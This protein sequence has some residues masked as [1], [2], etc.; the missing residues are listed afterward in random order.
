VIIKNFTQLAKTEE[1]KLALE[2]IDAGLAAIDT[3]KIIKETISLGKNELRVGNESFS[4]NEIARIFVVG[5][6][7]CALSAAGALEEI[8]GRKLS[9]GIVIDVRSGKLNKIKTISGD[10]PMPSEKNVFATDEIIELLKNTS[11]KDLV[12]FIISGGGSTLLCHPENMTCLDEAEILKYLYGSGANIKKI[13]T[14]RK[15]ISTARG[16]FLAK[17][18]YPARA[19][20]LIFSD[21]PGDDLEFIASGPTVK[22]TTTVEDAKKIVDEFDL[23]KKTGLKKINLVE[24]PKENKYFENIK[25]ILVVSNKVALEAMR[26]KAESA[27]FNAE[28][29]TTTLSG[30]SEDVGLEIA[31]KLHSEKD[32]TVLLYGGETVVTSHATGKGGRAQELALSAM[33]VLRDNELVIAV[34]SDGRDNTD[35]AGGLCDNI[36][37]MKAGELDLVPGDYLMENKSYYFFEKTG[38]YIETGDTGRNVADFVIA[39]KS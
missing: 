26:E 27:G 20:S 33:R 28:I 6:G 13:N 35:F 21:V 39:I 23:E 5:V 38:D 3:Q 11:E 1:R 25:N 12:I 34:G 32:K 29:V 2:M 4:L 36:T 16:G 22:D 30:E 18:A 15:H 19:I 24:T 37:K 8:L 10:H 9:G 7:K 14:V 17:Y 31:K